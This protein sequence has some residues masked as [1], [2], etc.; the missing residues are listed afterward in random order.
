MRTTLSL[1]A[2]GFLE[3]TKGYMKGARVRTYLGLRKGNCPNE[4]KAKEVWQ[5][6]PAHLTNL[7]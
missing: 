1:R 7:A 4:E 3:V 2:R 5:A 6:F